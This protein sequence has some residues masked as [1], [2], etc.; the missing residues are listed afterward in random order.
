MAIIAYSCKSMSLLLVRGGRSSSIGRG[1]VEP[2]W[3][4]GH[5]TRLTS[6]AVA[7]SESSKP[8]LGRNGE[9]CRLLEDGLDSWGGVVA[10]FTLI[11]LLLYVGPALGRGCRLAGGRKKDCVMVD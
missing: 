5:N 7:R 4:F 2:A 1:S 11:E 10:A 3:T 6:A 9:E 8:W